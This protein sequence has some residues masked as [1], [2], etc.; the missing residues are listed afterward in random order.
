LK[1]NLVCLLAGCSFAPM[2]E[3]GSN[4]LMEALCLYEKKIDSESS[5]FEKCLSGT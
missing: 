1:I 3:E 5:D 4:A 2:Q